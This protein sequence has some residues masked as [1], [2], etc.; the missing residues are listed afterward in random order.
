LGIDLTQQMRA[1]GFLLD[2][3]ATMPASLLVGLR[4]H[5]TSLFDESD[6][7]MWFGM[8]LTKE[9][10]APQAIRQGIKSLFLS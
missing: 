6:I 4:R 3:T 7:E 9:N 10:H 1:S 8:N 5:S 2:S